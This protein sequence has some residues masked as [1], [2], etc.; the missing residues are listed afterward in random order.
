[1]THN[2]DDYYKDVKIMEKDQGRAIK[3]LLCTA[4]GKECSTCDGKNENGDDCPFY[5]TTKGR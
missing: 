5:K 1:M 2:N 3:Q 4:H